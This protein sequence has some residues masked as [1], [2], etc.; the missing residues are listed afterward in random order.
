M[1]RQEVFQE[2]RVPNFI[3]EPSDEL[4]KHLNAIVDLRAGESASAVA[5]LVEAEAERSLCSGAWNG[6][7]FSDFRDLDDLTSSFFEVLSSGGEYHW[8]PFDQVQRT[9]FHP[10]RRVRDLLWRSAHMDLRG[11]E[12]LD[13]YL[14][15]LYAGTEWGDDDALRLGRGTEWHDANEG[16]VRGAGLRMYLVDELDKTI[17]EFNEISFETHV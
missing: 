4:T 13:V 16:P 8:I 2:G 1:A 6:Q 5:A 7:S 11:G 14:P 9:E 17:L 10:P 12:S 15:A 3:R